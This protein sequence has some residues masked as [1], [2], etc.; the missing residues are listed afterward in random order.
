[1]QTALIYL[2][3]YVLFFFI[4]LLPLIRK[5]EKKALFI[6]IPIFIL[7]FAA[8]IMISFAFKLPTIDVITQKILQTLHMQ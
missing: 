2:F 4:D 5:K 8:D 1:M 3:L 6:Y 7:T